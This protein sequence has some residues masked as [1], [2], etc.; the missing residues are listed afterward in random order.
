[1]GA[2]VRS[3]AVCGAGLD[4]LRADAR[5]CST[6]CRTDASRLGRLL[7]GRPVDGFASVADYLDRYGRRNAAEACK[8]GRENVLTAPPD[9]E[10]ETRTSRAG[11]FVARRCRERP[12]HVTF[13]RRIY[14][15][16]LRWGEEHEPDAPLSE[17]AFYRVVEDW[18]PHEGRARVPLGGKGR[19]RLAF[20][21]I[22]LTRKGGAAVDERRPGA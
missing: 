21:G 16:Y 18:A 15:A 12:G 19:P 7:A 6:A 9:P 11:R 5:Y 3:C 2:V 17:S 14:A 8:R 13:A 10:P 4:G 1:M 22:V 20:L